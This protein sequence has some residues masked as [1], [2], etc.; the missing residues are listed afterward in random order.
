MRWITFLGIVSMITL[1]WLAGCMTGT[2]AEDGKITTRNL[3]HNTAVL[4]DDS[5]VAGGID[6]PY[7]LWTDADQ[8][9]V[10]GPL[11]ETAMTL[12]LPNGLALHLSSPKDGTIGALIVTFTE[13]GEIAGV[14]VN[15]LTYSISDPTAARAATIDLLVQYASR[16]SEDRRAEFIAFVETFDAE[17]AEA[18]L[19]R[20]RA[21]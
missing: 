1:I 17:L 2:T 3:G 18:I 16:M 9:S 21:P 4:T 20:I 8:H 10:T 15:D 7:T 14:S 13:T 12:S 5:I 11:A 6:Q 19:T